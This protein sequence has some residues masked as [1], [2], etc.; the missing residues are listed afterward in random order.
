MPYST[1]PGHTSPSD[2]HVG[3]KP[4]VEKQVNLQHPQ[5]RRDAR[6]WVENN[7]THRYKRVGV[8]NVYLVPTSTGVA[9]NTDDRDI[10]PEVAP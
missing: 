10:W 4:L 8:R 1:R 3:L 9:Q 5:T 6:M 2:G 7:L